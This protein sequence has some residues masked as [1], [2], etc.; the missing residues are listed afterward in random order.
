[1]GGGEVA[2]TLVTLEPEVVERHEAQML[3]RGG[4]QEPDYDRRPNA[5]RV[6]RRLVLR[7][8]SGPVSRRPR[9]TK[10]LTGWGRMADDVIEPTEAD[11]QEAERVARADLTRII[12]RHATPPAVE[13]GT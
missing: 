10:M 6:S 12:E 8:G 7:F 5:V 3:L 9:V 1:M 4:W 13:P 2:V 11:W